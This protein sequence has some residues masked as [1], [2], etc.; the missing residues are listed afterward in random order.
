MKQPSTILM[1]VCLLF[2][3]AAI[4][5]LAQQNSNRQQV[6]WAKLNAGFSGATFVGGS[7]ACLACHE[8]TS[9]KYLETTHGRLFG[10]SMKGADCES[11][12]GPRSKHVEEA[13]G[14]L[15]LS[16]EQ[17]S[18]VCMQCHQGGNRMNWHSS[19]HKS[20]DV[21]CVSC[22]TVMEK[23]SAKALLSK[24][25]QLALCSTCHADVKA[26]LMRTSRHP[27]QEGKLDCS[28]CHN[29]HG[30]PG[31]A[32][33]AKGAVN[34]TCYS[35]HQEKRGPFL[36]EHPPVREDCL[37][38]HQ[39][40]GSNNRSLLTTQSASLCVSC[41]QYGGHVNEFRYNRVSTPYGNG[42]VNCHTAI[43]GSNHPSGIRFTR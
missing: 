42:C 26:K 15:A 25:D 16:V 24:T 18:V 38:C 33:L 37:S 43:H 41:H 30:A 28:S 29:A 20:A 1:P 40:H 36:W 10:G 23:R 34:E 22:H 12:H 14:S 7:A 2:L 11:C 35:C 13:D 21:G 5:L 27:V 6:D 4:P 19:L 3:L 32:M 39:P 31:R 8:E 17:Y 9:Q